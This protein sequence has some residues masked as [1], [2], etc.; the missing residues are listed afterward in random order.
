M[1]SRYLTLAV[2]VTVTLASLIGLAW[3]L[4][5]IPRPG[6]AYT[7][8]L[9]D[10]AGLVEGNAVR[11]AGVM[12]GQIRRIS[13]DGNEALVELRIN[14]EVRIFAASCASPQMKG[15]LGEKF[16]QIRQPPAGSELAPGSEI[17]CIDPSVDI[18]EALNSMSGVVD[19]KDSLYE[20]IARIVRRMDSLTGALD[21][22]GLPRERVDNLLAE[23][24]ATAREGRA[25]L[26]ENRED[27]RAI[28]KASR[29]LLEDPKLR[30]MIDNGDATLAALKREVPGLL[31][32]GER[33]IADGE[34]ALK[35]VEAKLDAVDDDKIKKIVADAQAGVAG[36]RGL[37]D[38]LRGIAKTSL[39]LLK[40]LGKLVDRALAVDEKV[41]RQFF[42]IEGMRI[43]IGTPY[44]VRG[45]VKELEGGEEQP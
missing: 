6:K 27:L 26:A 9:A 3:T 45:K 29:A 40:G 10:A 19:S 17:A 23:L 42:Q 2:F 35:K 43:R 20:P 24:Q 18:G 38:D 8:R 4:G 32:D 22:Q 30:R 14:P 25:M 31:D 1:N 5:A 36:M 39:P 16:L 7:V 34:R 28:V 21:D 44:G 11:I 13:V 33:L 37:A 12:V 15:L 41:I